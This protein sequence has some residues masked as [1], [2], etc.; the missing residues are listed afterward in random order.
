MTVRS[1]ESKNYDLRPLELS[2]AALAEVLELFI[3]GGSAIKGDWSFLD[4]Q[5]NQNPAGKAIGFNAYYGCKLV[6]HYVT[7]PIIS[8]LFGRETR[9]VLSINTRTDP[10]H[11]GQGLFTRLA[12]LTYARAKELGN[13]FVVGIANQN[14]VHGFVKKLGFQH[15]GM[16]ET[17]FVV[18]FPPDT[19]ARVDYRTVW[20]KESV[21]WRLNNPTKRYQCKRV[22]PRTYL[23]GNSNRFRALIGEVAATST[24]VELLE[25]PPSLNILKLWIG[26]SANSDWSRSLNIKVPQRL[27]SVPLNFIFR[28]LV[29]TRI[30]SPNSVNFWA[31]DF[32]SY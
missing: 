5:Y 24:P 11:Q 29:G 12:E 26:I 13:E 32:D 25:S 27:K 19:G 3:R 14:S 7:I 28:D 30:L 4:W 10:E 6:A 1:R 31:M 2:P 21:T 23:F 17:R 8:S 22:G 20:S 15:V 16:L 9:G 18:S